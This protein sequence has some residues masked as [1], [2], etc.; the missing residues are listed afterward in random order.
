M[1]PSLAAVAM[2]Q[3]ILTCLHNRVISFPRSDFCQ[4]PSALLRDFYEVYSSSEPSSRWTS[5]IVST[6]CLASCMMYCKA[7]LASQVRPMMTHKQI[8]FMKN[9]ARIHDKIYMI[10]VQKS[11][12]S[13]WCP[14]Q[15]QE[16]KERYSAVFVTCCFRERISPFKELCD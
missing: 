7:W 13:I 3:L 9:Y 16:K 1:S 2:A 4:H 15:K 10:R 6:S 12:G 8:P 5:S 14:T 11:N